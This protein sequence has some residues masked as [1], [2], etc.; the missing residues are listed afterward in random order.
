MH[1]YKQCGSGLLVG[2]HAVTAAPGFVRSLVFR[3]WLLAE[4]EINNIKSE[5]FIE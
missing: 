4:A 3:R 1:V 5:Q 2:V